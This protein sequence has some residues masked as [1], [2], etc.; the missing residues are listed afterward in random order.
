MIDETVTWAELTAAM[1]AEGYRFIV[2]IHH[3]EGAGGNAWPASPE[4]AG[5]VSTKGHDS[6]DGALV[7]LLEQCRERWPKDSSAPHPFDGMDLEA[8]FREADRRDWDIGS[9]ETTGVLGRDPVPEGA[10]EFS[11]WVSRS[12]SPK[13]LSFQGCAATILDAVRAAMKEAGC[14]DA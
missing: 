12:A 14:A 1:A 4:M 9:V 6:R 5:Q 13:C 11:C 2:T 7:D 8:L 10:F 3:S